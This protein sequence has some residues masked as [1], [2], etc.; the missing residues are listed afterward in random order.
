MFKLKILLSYF[1]FVSELS[2]RFNSLFVSRLKRK[3][4]NALLDVYV[5][6]LKVLV[7][8]SSLILKLAKESQ[9][10]WWM[11]LLNWKKMP[12][13]TLKFSHRTFTV[14]CFQLKFLFTSIDI[15]FILISFL[16]ADRANVDLVK[17]WCAEL[18][19]NNNRY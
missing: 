14:T 19:N 13:E 6:R 17:N 3:E 12:I 8:R 10:N 18:N 15:I 16:K 11:E 4:E 2:F 5:Y 7:E 9:F 1:S